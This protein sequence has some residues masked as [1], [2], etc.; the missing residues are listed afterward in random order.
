MKVIDD[1]KTHQQIFNKGYRFNPEDEIFYHNDETEF[2]FPE[3]DLYNDWKVELFDRYHYLNE[4]LL[5]LGID[6][7]SNQVEVFGEDGTKVDMKIFNAN[8]FGDIE[9]L[10]FSLHRRAH[11]YAKNSTSAGTKFEYNVQKRLNPLYALFCEGK[12]DFSEAI[13]APFWHPVLIDLFEKQQ[14]IETLVITEGQFKS[15]KACNE[16]IYCV[17]LTSI[18]HFKD[19]KTNSIHPEI[20]EFIQQCKV[21][22]V[23]ILWDGDCK[24]ISSKHLEQKKELTTRPAMFY[25]FANTIKKLIHGLISPKKITVYF[26]TIKSS[27]IESEPKGIDDLLLVSSL[28]KGAVLND[29]TQIGKIPGYLID[30]ININ[31]EYGSKQLR[32]YFSLDYVGDFYKQHQEIIKGRNFVFYG[33][34]YRIEKGVPIIEVAKELKDYFRIGSD[35]FRLIKQYSYNNDSEVINVEKTVVPWKKAEIK[36]DFGKNAIDNVVRLDG[37]CNIPNNVN[38]K[39]IVDNQYNLY[40]DVKHEVVPGEWPT[41]RKFL[42]HIFQEQYEMGLDYIQLL[43]SKPYQK[44]PVLSLVSKEEGTG[45]STFLKFLY[46]I[47]QNNMTFVTPDDILGQWTS[48]WSS[49]LIVASEETFFDKKEAL[50]KIKNISTADKLMRNERFVNSSLIDNFL[51]F[52]FCS[53]HEDDFIKLNDGATRFWILKVKKIKDEDKDEGLNEKMRNEIP[54]FIYY[55]NNRLLVNPCRDRMWFHPDQFR[56]EAFYNIVKHSEPTIIKDLRIKIEEYFHKYDTDVFKVCV[57]DLK[58]YFGVS[59]SN[60][61]FYLNKILKQFFMVEKMDSAHRYEF[62]YDSN[63]PDKPNVFK[64]KGRHLVFNRV[65]FVGEKPITSQASLGTL[66][67]KM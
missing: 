28:P 64:G 15:F 1:F 13:N 37:F 43:Y 7:A 67:F 56:T 25:N 45:K 44:L 6:E 14:E 34:T 20:I 21:K 3:G 54:H 55:L 26:A 17:G 12:Y 61:D 9:I 51:K 27:E 58:Q 38:Y 23:V 63:E 8:K 2:R 46:M 39:Q 30:W 18:S 19:K 47:F 10:Q 53:N 52:V 24:N 57:S 31:N 16:G 40:S 41:I 65:D 48:H 49:K 32:R 4:R 35:Y 36:E 29:F 60:N 11:I 22:N 66:N 59:G 5:E 42:E 50:E 33:T 62:F